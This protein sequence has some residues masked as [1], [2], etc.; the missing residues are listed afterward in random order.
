MLDFLDLQN[1]LVFDIETAP[2]FKQFDELS[3]VFKAHWEN[4]L[5]KKRADDENEADFYFNNA[6]I[7]AEFGKIICISAGY[8]RP[9]EGNTDNW[10][11]TVTSFA[12][13]NE[14]HLLQQFA[15]VLN[16]HYNN[17]ARHYL[18]GHNIKEFDVPYVC[19]RMLIH[20][21]TLPSIIDVA[22]KKPWEVK[23]IDTMELWK[24]GDYKNFT[25]LNLLTELFNI[26]TPKDDIDGSDVGRV[27]WHE[28]DLPRITEYCQKDV[29]AVAQL[30]L[31]FK[32]IPLLTEANISFT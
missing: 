2:G 4:K 26:P 13:H 16:K 1:V 6:G 25:K 32:K 18:C 28:D 31:R 21:I 20:G 27:Y 22:G 7:Y 3:D 8:F 15:D 29:L 10:Q 12:S 17:P 14:A 5:G 9:V 23:Y 30:V 11:F 24:F 19:R